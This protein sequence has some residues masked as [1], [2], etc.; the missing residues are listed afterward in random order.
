MAHAH[1]WMMASA[2]HSARH[3]DTS[4]VAVDTGGARAGQHV[5]CLLLEEICRRR[6]RGRRC[7]VVVAARCGGGGGVARLRLG[8]LIHG[9]AVGGVE[10]RS[11]DCC[12]G[13]RSCSH[14]GRMLL[15][16]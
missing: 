16:R 12:R 2:G 3:D 10:S 15:M 1:V 4:S 6:R 9:R 11:R 7:R 5:G 8:L 14:G 13:R